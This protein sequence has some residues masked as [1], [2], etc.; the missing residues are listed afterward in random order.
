MFLLSSPTFPPALSGP[1]C[2]LTIFFLHSFLFLILWRLLP[3]LKQADSE[4]TLNRA[5]SLGSAGGSSTLAS[6]V[7]E[8]Q[9]EQAEKH[10]EQ[11]EKKDAT[12][13]LE[14]GMEED[15]DEEL[16]ALCALPALSITEEIL[17]FINQSRAREEL[18]SKEQGL[19]Q[20]PEIQPTTHERNFTCP[21]PPVACSPEQ[22]F[23]MQPHQEDDTS[24]VKQL[25]G[26]ENGLERESG[27]TV[28]EEEE[29]EMAP[30][31][32]VESE[33]D[34]K[35]MTDQGQQGITVPTPTPSSPAQLYSSIP[36]MED[37]KA[38]NHSQQEETVDCCTNSEEYHQ[39]TKSHKAKRAS[40]L[41][42]R[43][44]RIIEKIRSYYEAAAEL[45]EDESG[46]EAREREGELSSRRDSFSQIPIGLVKKSVSQFD[47]SGC[48]QGDEK[49]TTEPTQT[50]TG[51]EV[52]P[53][54]FLQPLDSTEDHEALADT[55][56]IV[57]DLKDE[58]ENLGNKLPTSIQL[59]ENE[60]QN[61]SITIGPAETG[62]EIEE[63]I[64][65]ICKELS[66]EELNEGA[67]NSKDESLQE[68][69]VGLN[70]GNS[71]ITAGVPLEQ[72]AMT[73]SEYNLKEPAEPPGS[74]KKSSRPLS[75][76]PSCQKYASTSTRTKTSKNLEELPSQLLVGRGSRPSNI[77]TTNRALFEGKLSDITGIGLF[78]ANPVADPSL[79]ENS[80]RILSKVQT[81]ARMYS[82]KA[83]T[84]KVPL[85]QKRAIFLRNKIGDLTELSGVSTQTK[86]QVSWDFNNK[87]KTQINKQPKCVQISPRPTDAELKTKL[88]TKTQAQR[89]LQ[90]KVQ[91]DI[92]TFH[93]SPSDHQ[94]GNNSQVLAGV[95][96]YTKPN[97]NKQNH[98]VTQEE[99]RSVEENISTQAQNK[100]VQKV[101]PNDQLVFVKD[102]QNTTNGFI[103]Y[104]P[105]DF[106]LAL[107][108]DQDQCTEH[109]HSETSIPLDKM[110]PISPIISSSSVNMA[111]SNTIRSE[112]S[113]RTNVYAEHC[114]SVNSIGHDH[115]SLSAHLADGSIS[116]DTAAHYKYKQ[117]LPA[118]EENHVPAFQIPPK[119]SESTTQ[120]SQDIHNVRTE[121][122]YFVRNGRRDGESSPP[123]LS[124]THS[125][126]PSQC[127]TLVSQEP[128]QPAVDPPK[129]S[130]NMQEGGF[131][132]LSV[133]GPSSKQ[134]LKVISKAQCDLMNSSHTFT[135][136][137]E[138]NI[139]R[140]AF[141]RHP[142]GPWG[143]SPVPLLESNASRPQPPT[144]LFDYGEVL[145][146]DLTWKPENKCP[147]SRMSTPVT[148]CCSPS[149]A[150]SDVC[151]TSKPTKATPD[152]DTDVRRSSPAFRP[153][154][155]RTSPSPLSPNLTPTSFPARAPTC[156]SPFRAIPL[157][158]PTL[159]NESFVPSYT[160]SQTP[161]YFPALQSSGKSFSKR[162]TPASSLT[163]SSAFSG[164]SSSMEAG[165]SASSTISSSLHSLPCSS[166]VVSSSTFT[167]SLAASCISQSI[168]QS[169]AKK[170]SVRQ[171]V[172]ASSTRNP[173]SSPSLPSSHLP[174]C[175]PSPRLPPTR[176]GCTTPAYSHL[177]CTINENQHPRYSPSSL[178]STCPSP[179]S[180]P[181]PL[182]SL[183][184]SAS[185]FPHNRQ[186]HQT[187]LS[188]TYAPFH[189]SLNHQ[190]DSSQNVN[191]SN[192]V[193]LPAFNTT[194]FNSTSAIYDLSNR[195]W[196]ASPQKMQLGNGSTSNT[197]AQQPNDNLAFGSHNR[198]AR[199]FSAS[200]PNSRVQSPFQCVSPASF[201]GLC[202][203]PP[204]HNYSSPMANRPPHPRGSRMGGANYHNPLGL[205]LEIP[206]ISTASQTSPHFSPQI[207]SPPPIG[208]SVWT[209]DVAVP[210]ARNP[211]T[212]SPSLF[213]SCSG[214]QSPANAYFP[215][216]HPPSAPLHNLT[217][218][219]SPPGP[220]AF[221]KKPPSLQRSLSNLS[222]KSTSPT[223]SRHGGL[224]S[225]RSLGFTG[226]YQ[227]LFDQK[228]GPTSPRSVRSSYDSSP[229]GLSPREELQSPVSPRRF[230]PTGGNLGWQHFTNEPLLDGQELCNKYNESGSCTSSR[231]SFSQS[232]GC[233]LAVP[234][235]QAQRED[236]EVEEGNCRSQLIYA[237]VGG[238]AQDPNFYV[239]SLSSPPAA[240][241][242]SQLKAPHQVPV[243]N[244]GASVQ[245]VAS[246]LTKVSSQ[247]TSYATTVNLQIAGSGRITSFSTAH[248]S[249]SQPLQ[250]GSGSG[251]LQIGRR[252]SINGLSHT[253]SPLP[254][255]CSQQL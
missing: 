85:H 110:P 133:S 213:F 56:L 28:Y 59:E 66:H 117:D 247:K 255:N 101:V 98:I 35:A 86:N 19:D 160:V 91:S 96:N 135:S 74:L 124:S 231:T 71:G 2:L 248:V 111:T 131:E 8:V 191:N 129:E 159:C 125:L 143:P 225:H 42:N 210:Q 224:R 151:E 67:D 40:A 170:N 208:V 180:A 167:R 130:V 116:K 18:V 147:G 121:S 150:L 181:S 46:E 175:S 240:H 220:F 76:T 154:L 20:V 235:S 245:P 207:L 195:H 7:I 37:S 113:G 227:D 52:E 187:S 168:S 47:L 92:I 250:V 137:P 109:R 41:S 164:R 141:L 144:M 230:I 193:S 128:K 39:P 68:E 48:Q 238:P 192:N 115:S 242:Q 31:A 90:T 229:S 126:T 38:S 157:S 249:V 200:E 251:E 243:A 106:I 146:P 58:E 62:K 152:Q 199:P 178:R 10:H 1:W 165:P 99:K 197:A 45:E 218:A 244:I 221:P 171:Q 103:L 185:S 127:H 13:S 190:M 50:E 228:S 188:T 156:S 24:V 149:Q 194:H 232:L 142:G 212:T 55:P 95:Q 239:S 222:D 60:T 44:K 57:M 174:R 4:G 36:T 202:S 97:S 112:P 223:Q 100:K 63:D 64:G 184:K 123:E 166:P 102:Q 155:K 12:K 198:V 73:E 104:R 43:D 176:E 214:Q 3:A 65:I 79:M 120:P 203:P 139:S 72:I 140:P 138:L 15:D 61:E 153:S 173:S 209:R 241:H 107:N 5:D 236:P 226:N 169:L 53:S 177:G 162:T 78:E 172:Q 14:F 206:E 94:N 34:L 217:R 11:E 88:D 132:D 77:V 27:T 186:G 136:S 33:I 6:S 254:Q 118:Q 49:Q 32:K 23:T 29:Q 182:H 22:M 204:P 21:L 233:S 105:R 234:V 70:T 25:T 26:S 82:A 119:Y 183:A 93:T 189:Q 158:S 17:E 51:R 75:E 196:S 89:L 80:E 219:A 246:S 122:E 253:S 252:I 237:Y 87:C 9:S 145:F 54:T 69:D 30:E 163:P 216:S 148:Q 81:L 201:N 114:P 83:S 108:K 134:H 211:Q 215:T 84:M 179:S 16:A 205:T 161:T